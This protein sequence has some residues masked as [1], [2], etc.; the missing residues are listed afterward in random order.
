MAR[1]AARFPGSVLYGARDTAGALAGALLAAVLAARAH[2]AQRLARCRLVPPALARRTVG[3]PGGALRSAFGAT[4]AFART[5]LACVLAR[6]A[7]GAIHRHATTVGA[8]GAIVA[9]VV[10]RGL[11]VIEG[12]I[13]SRRANRT[14]SRSVGVGV[15]ADLAHRAF[16]A[17]RFTAV[18]SLWTGFAG[19]T[20][21]GR[22][23]GAWRGQRCGL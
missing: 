7:G 8:A 6:G 12:I 23:G 5:R 11:R 10:K 20:V 14:F 18:R 13:S 19:T 16:A 3:R 2:E 15:A 4:V 1:C 21:G 9:A 22:A 17:A